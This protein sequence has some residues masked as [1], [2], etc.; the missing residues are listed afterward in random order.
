MTI[1]IL[2][3]RFLMIFTRPSVPNYPEPLKTSNSFSKPI[4]LLFSFNQV[5]QDWIS[6]FCFGF[7]GFHW[8]WPGQ[9]IQN[10]SLT[11]NNWDPFSTKFVLLFLSH[12]SSFTC[13]SRFWF[14]SSNHSR[15]S[16]GQ[17]SF[18]VSGLDL[19]SSSRENYS[20]HF[21]C[22]LHLSGVSHKLSI[23]W[24]KS[25]LALGSCIQE[26]SLWLSL[27]LY[28]RQ[29]HHPTPTCICSCSSSIFQFISILISFIQES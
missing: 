27:Y 8:I 4:V 12:W 1:L 23:L 28:F 25:G 6:W 20:T 10:F 29:I 7:S 2:I 17:V 24:T 14:E 3:L 21:P 15:I 18:C 19:G 22:F 26:I 9:V 11:C 13:E 5:P 16:P